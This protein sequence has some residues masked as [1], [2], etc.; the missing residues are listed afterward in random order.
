MTCSDFCFVKFTLMSGSRGASAFAWE[1][2]RQGD[3]ALEEL[4]IWWGV[5][6]M[7]T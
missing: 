6:T 5:L 4:E 1:P 2:R 3:P 7:D